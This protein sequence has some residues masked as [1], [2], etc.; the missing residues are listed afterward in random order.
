MSLYGSL[1]WSNAT[2]VEPSINISEGIGEEESRNMVDE[3][4]DV[5]ENPIGVSTEELINAMVNEPADD[6]NDL[7]ANKVPK[8]TEQSSKKSLDLTNKKSRIPL[9]KDFVG[10]SFEESEDITA[11]ESIHFSVEQTISNLEF[12]EVTSEDM[13]DDKNIADSMVVKF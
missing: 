8:E 3:F 12:V 4:K 13:T 5:L 9:M 7:T 2:G 11:E 1:D 6:K 10:F